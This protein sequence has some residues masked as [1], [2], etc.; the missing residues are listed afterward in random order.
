MPEHSLAVPPGAKLAPAGRYKGGSKK[1][2]QHFR[3]VEVGNKFNMDDLLQVL[4]AHLSILVERMAPD[5]EQLESSEVY[6]RLIDAKFDKREA[7]QIAKAIAASTVDSKEIAIIARELRETLQT[8]AEMEGMVQVGKVRTLMA[9]VSRV[10]KEEV[11]DEAA[12]T[13]VL[14]RLTNLPL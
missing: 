13:R 7:S 12:Y 4:N 8:V 5:D 1:L 11:K 2:K 14:T 6:A 10:I 3:D 9:A